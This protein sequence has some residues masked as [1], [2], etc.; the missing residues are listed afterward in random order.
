M[1]RWRICRSRNVSDLEWKNELSSIALSPIGSN[2]ESIPLYR[3]VRLG[4]LRRR[5]VLQSCA[6]LLFLSS[7]LSLLDW[8]P[9]G[10]LWDSHAASLGGWQVGFHDPTAAGVG[11]SDIPLDGLAIFAAIFRDGVLISL[12]AA[13]DAGMRRDSEA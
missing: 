4:A 13:F 3:S 5:L 10:L 8:N 12:G 11:N 2:S 6:V 9:P 7:G 1:L